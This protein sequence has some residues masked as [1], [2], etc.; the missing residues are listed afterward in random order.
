MDNITIYPQANSAAADFFIDGGYLRGQ[1]KNEGP[2][3]VRPAKLAEALLAHWTGPWR[4]KPI[5]PSRYFWFDAIAAD[6]PKVREY[7]KRIELLPD[8]AVE[9]GR[10]VAGRNR[11][12]KG[13]DG[14]LAVV[15]LSGAHRRVYDVAFLVAGDADFVPLVTAIREV[16][17]LV[18]VAG[19]DDSMAEELRKAADRAISLP[20]ISQP[21]WS[22]ISL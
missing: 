12:Q 19:F 13:V 22:Q 10:V 15:A 5:T 8:T 21:F 14:R 7:V 2:W 11:R 20:D 16:G 1:F 3:Q 17:P 18:V 4:G 6:E 9:E